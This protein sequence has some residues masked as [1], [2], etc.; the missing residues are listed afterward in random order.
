MLVVV[1]LFWEECEIILLKV[2]LIEFF[3]KKDGGEIKVRLEV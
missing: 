3:D 1:L 2:F